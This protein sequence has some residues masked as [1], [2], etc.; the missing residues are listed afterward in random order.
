M[1]IKKAVWKWVALTGA[2]AAVVLWAGWRIYCS[3]FSPY[4]GSIGT[5]AVIKDKEWENNGEVKGG[6]YYLTVE[7]IGGQETCLRLRMCGDLEKQRLVYEALIVGEEYGIDFF[8]KIPRK[9]AEQNG[10][11]IMPEDAEEQGIAM[12]GTEMMIYSDKLLGNSELAEK[13]VEIKY[14]SAIVVQ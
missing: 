4:M 13:Y 14:V 5:W 10:L 2:L 7:D 8:Y 12:A 1:G 9:I 3:F 11:L 6:V